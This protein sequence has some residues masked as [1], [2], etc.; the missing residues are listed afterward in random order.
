MP[1]FRLPLRA[2]DVEPEVDL[3]ALL[4][5][6]YELSGYDYFIDYNSDTMPPLSESDAAW[7]DALLREKELRG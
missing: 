2:G 7:M 5:G 6:V 4:H 1:A 3:Q